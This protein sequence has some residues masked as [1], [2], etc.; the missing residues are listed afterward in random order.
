M[1]AGIDRIISGTDH[2]MFLLTK[3]Y[4]NPILFLRLD[5]YNFN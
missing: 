5:F 4:K 2:A 1:I 3:Y